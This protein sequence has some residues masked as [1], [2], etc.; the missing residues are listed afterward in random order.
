MLGVVNKIQRHTTIVVIV[1]PS[2]PASSYLLI[3]TAQSSPIERW[4]Q[5]LDALLEAEAF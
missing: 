2:G 1:A 5:P 4:P 3:K